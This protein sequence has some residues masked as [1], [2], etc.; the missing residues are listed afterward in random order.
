MYS[1]D[2]IS[3][4]TQSNKFIDVCGELNKIKD[5]KLRGTYFEWFAKLVLQY[6]PR[7]SNFVKKC[8]LLEELPEKLRTHLEIPVNDIGID[9]II[10]THSNTYFAVQVKYRKNIDCVI[11]WSVLSTFFGLTFG[12]TNKF[13]KGIFFTNTC[14]TTK[15]IKGKQNIINILNHSLNDISNNTFTKIKIALLKTTINDKQ[16]YSPRDYQELII[17]NAIYYYTKND[18]GR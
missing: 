13:E 8:M 6:D 15:Y 1:K 10:E 16:L 11:N 9:L 14:D 18:K 12:L 5:N 17:A 7:Y 4:I 3:I 2:F